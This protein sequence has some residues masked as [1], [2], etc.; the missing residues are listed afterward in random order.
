ML[1]FQNDDIRKD[2][3]FVLKFAKRIGKL[4]NFLHVIR[5]LN[6]KSKN[7]PRGS[8]LLIGYDFAKHS[9][10]FV[11]EDWMVGG[12]IFHRRSAEWCAHT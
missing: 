1:V 10:G 8:K 4:D 5:S 12:I 3:I 11:L 6:Y 2:F 7:N 9:F